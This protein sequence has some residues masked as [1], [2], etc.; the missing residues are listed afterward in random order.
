MANVAGGT[1]PPDES[2]KQINENS[3]DNQKGGCNTK[4]ADLL[5]PK[6]VDN[7]SIRVPPKPVI[8]LHGEPT[9]MWKSS[10]VRNPIMQEKLQYAIIEK[11]FHDKPHID[12]LRK[13]IPAQCGIKGNFT[14]IIYNNILH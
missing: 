5:K 13:S 3:N 10:D 9:I 7:N 4:F 1:V 14:I 6:A 11:F 12:V 2:N 8:M